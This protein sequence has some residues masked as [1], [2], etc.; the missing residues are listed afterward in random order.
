MGV[1]LHNECQC[2]INIIGDVSHIIDTRRKAVGLKVG[3]SNDRVATSKEVS[4][5]DKAPEAVL[6]L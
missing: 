6:L 2:E 1:Q 4:F 3:V 5:E